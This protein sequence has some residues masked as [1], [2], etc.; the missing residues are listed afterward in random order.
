MATH[1]SILAWRTPWAE[2]PGK[3]QSMVSERVMYTVIFIYMYIYN[4]ASLIAQ[5][6]KNLPAMQETPETL[7]LFL[8]QEESPGEGNG[9]RLQYSCLE[10][11]MG[12]GAWRATIHGVS[13]S[14]T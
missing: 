7:V 13:K 2:E 8:G 1:S 10:N 9:Y 3:L 11:P 12:R 6:V 4:W 5:L 14:Q